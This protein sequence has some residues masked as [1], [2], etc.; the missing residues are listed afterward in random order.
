MQNPTRV[1]CVIGSMG[2]GGSERQMAEVLTHLDRNRFQPL[3]YTVYREGPLLDEV[4]EDVPVFSFWEDRRPPRWYWPGRIRRMQVRHL[5]GIAQAE[6]VDLILD[7]TIH[8]TLIAAPAAWRAGVPEIPVIVS[9]PQSDLR[10]I[11]RFVAAKRRLLRQAYSRAARVVAVSSDL[12][13]EAIRCYNLPEQQVVVVRNGIDLRRIDRLAAAPAP[14]FPPGLFHVIQVGRLQ[15]EKG[16]RI[17]IEAVAELVLRRTR[18]AL[19][20]HLVGDGRDERL[21]KELVAQRGLEQH[22]CFLGRQANPLPLVRQADLFCIPSLFEGMPNA[23]LEAMACRTPVLAADCPTGPREILDGGRF[24]RLVPPADPAALADAI[25]DAM[26]NHGRWRE[27]VEAARRHVEEHFA[28]EQSLALLES[29][30]QEAAGR[31]A[32]NG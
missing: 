9:H 14:A 16:Q 6:R 2:V 5:A 10:T 29:L 17:L 15:A 3:L 11:G 31:L 26:L 30:L 13:Q 21:L 8:T 22:V 7:R 1:L 19:V 23:L 32:R 27:R 24:G 18:T 12:R 28:L 25:E 4:P 20:A